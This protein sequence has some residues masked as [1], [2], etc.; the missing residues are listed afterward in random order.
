MAFFVTKDGLY[1]EGD[2]N[3]IE[4]IS[5]S[6]RPSAYHEYD[7]QT[8]KWVL[9][10]TLFNSARSRLINAVEEHYQNAVMFA[11]TEEKKSLRV[12][13]DILVNKIKNFTDPSQLDTIKI[14]F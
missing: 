12:S 13:A 8:K 10:K 9:N 4:D 6:R 2:R 14:D 7:F 1:Y 5:V 11:S 3:S